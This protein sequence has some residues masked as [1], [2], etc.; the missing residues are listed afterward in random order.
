MQRVVAF[1]EVF[2]ER[3]GMT[4]V[5]ELKNMNSGGCGQSVE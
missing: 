2:M 4:S 5:L 1:K 3:Y